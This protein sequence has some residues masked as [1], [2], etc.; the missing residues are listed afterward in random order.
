[1]DTLSGEQKL[2]AILAHVAYLFGG[3]GFIVAPLII[4]LLKKDDP[5]VY[6]HAKQA[7]IAQLSLA[8]FGA[9]VGVLSFLLIGILL[10]PVLAILGI[11]LLITSFVAAFKALDGQ[12][13]DYPLIQGFVSRF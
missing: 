3:L 11:V 12:L 6:Y 9:A 13:Y 8:L 7:L 2:L 5:F 1:M 10:L 4:F